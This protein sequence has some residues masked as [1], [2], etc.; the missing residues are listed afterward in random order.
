MIVVIGDG[1]DRSGDRDR[2]IRVAKRAASAGVRIHTLGFS[3]TDT[4]RPLLLLGELSK[5][6]LG[7]RASPTTR[8]R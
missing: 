7:T 5:R 1:R 3:P 2:V 6:S 8:S 4:R